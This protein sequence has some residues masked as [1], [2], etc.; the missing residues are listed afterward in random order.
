MPYQSLLQPSFPLPQDKAASLS[1]FRAAA[2]ILLHCP[3]LYHNTGRPASIDSFHLLRKPPS[4]CV[5]QLS[6]GLSLKTGLNGW[7]P[8]R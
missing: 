1:L 7:D 3:H 5:L 8:Y 4:T 6:L 2:V